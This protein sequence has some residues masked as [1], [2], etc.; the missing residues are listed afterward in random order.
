MEKNLFRNCRVIV[1]AKIAQI[2]VFKL[3]ICHL[4]IFAL[5][6][7]FFSLLLQCFGHICSSNEAYNL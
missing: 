6:L 7:N 2:K 4:A 1:V 3:A 5:C